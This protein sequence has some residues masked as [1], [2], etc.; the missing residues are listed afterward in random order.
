MA[1]SDLI[2]TSRHRRWAKQAETSKY[3]GIAE[4]TLATWRC[5]EP[6]RLPFH[7]NGRVILY[8]LDEVDAALAAHR[9]S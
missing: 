9:V 2:P 4:A 5:R 6:E 3:T 8:D 1:N 7:R